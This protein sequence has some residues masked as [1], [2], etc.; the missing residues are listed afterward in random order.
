MR[1]TCSILV[2]LILAACG[3]ADGVEGDASVADGAP[4]DGAVDGAIDGA[5]GVD[6]PTDDASAGDG[7]LADGGGICAPPGAGEISGSVGGVSIDMV[8]RAAASTGGFSPDHIFVI[9]EEMAGVC[10][11]DPF[12]PEPPGHYLIFAFRG[13]TSPGVYPY[14]HPSATS[15]PPYASGWLHVA[16]ADEPA[17]ESG[18]IT[19][20]A[21]DPCWQGSFDLTFAG[22]ETLTGT[23]SAPRCD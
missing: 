4:V 9:L 19:L 16:A 10:L 18:T 20:T 7:S 2:S 14:V 12:T 23:F 1:K 22:G 17:P 3:G 11:V 8:A 6:A 5:V 13:I 21:T 15:T